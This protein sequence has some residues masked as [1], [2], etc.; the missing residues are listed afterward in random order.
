MKMAVLSMRSV[1]NTKASSDD[2]Q[3]NWPLYY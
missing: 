2:E 1:V 3:K